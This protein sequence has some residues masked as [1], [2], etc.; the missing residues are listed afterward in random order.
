MWNGQQFTSP[1]QDLGPGSTIQQLSVLPTITNTTSNLSGNTKAVLLVTGFLNLGGSGNVSAA[2]YNGTT[3][4]PYLVASASDGAPG[5]FGRVFFKSYSMSVHNRRYMAVPFVILV[6]IASSLGVTFVLIL[7][8]LVVL[9]VKRR[10]EAKVECA[11]PW[12]YAG[13]PPL[14]PDA[15]LDMLTSGALATTGLYALSGGAGGDHDLDHSNEKGS[16]GSPLR[17][18]QIDAVQDNDDGDDD[19]STYGGAALGAGAAL[20][21][22]ATTM[23]NVTPSNG[24]PMSPPPAAYM[25]NPSSAFDGPYN[26]TSREMATVPP[27]LNTQRSSLSTNPFRVSS[28][29]IGMA[30]TDSPTSQQQQDT[31][32]SRGIVQGDVRWTDVNQDTSTLTYQNLP[33]NSQL[34]QQ[35]QQPNT[36]MMTTMTMPV[37]SLAQIERFTHDSVLWPNNDETQQRQQN[38][39]QQPGQQPVMWTHTTPERG[40][41]MVTNNNASGD[42][43]QQQPGQQ[44]GQQPVMWAHTTPERG[45]AMIANNNTSGGD[46]QQQQQLEQQPVTWTHTVPE[47][48]QALVTN[49]NMDG[50]DIQQQPPQQPAQQPV[51]WTNTVPERGQAMVTSN[52]ATDSTLFSL[53]PSHNNSYDHPTAIGVTAGFGAAV[54]AAAAMGARSS[55]LSVSTTSSSVDQQP[56]AATRAVTPSP[57]STYTSALNYQSIN[58]SHEHTASQDEG[59]SDENRIRWTHFDTENSQ[60]RLVIN[61]VSNTTPSMYSQYS[62]GD[63]LGGSPMPSTHDLGT[64]TT[65]GTTT[66]GASTASALGLSGDGLSSD[67]DIARWTT[68]PSQQQQPPSDDVAAVPP[69][70]VSMLNNSSSSHEEEDRPGSSMDRTTYTSGLRFSSVVLPDDVALP[71]KQSTSSSFDSSS[72][73]RSSTVSSLAS[74]YH[75]TINDFSH[76]QTTSNNISSQQKSTNDV[77]SEQQ[78]QPL[79]SSTTTTTNQHSTTNS[80]NT[81]QPPPLETFDTSTSEF[82]WSDI[83]ASSSPIQTTSTLPL[84]IHPQSSSSPLDISSSP[85]SAAAAA[86]AATATAATA[87]S[88]LDGRAASK[89]MIQDY[90]SSRD[91]TTN[92]ASLPDTLSAKRQKYKSDFKR[93]MQ[94]AL[95]N[96]SKGNATCSQEQPYLYVAKFDFS[97]RE[98][99]ELGFEKGDPIIVIDAEDDIWWMGYKDFKVG[100]DFDDD[101]DEPPQGVFPSNYVERATFLPY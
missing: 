61:Q 78:Q 60:D 13:K 44:S 62:L 81:A 94:A 64:T 89:K 50:S 35:Q 42:G 73:R 85:P 10:Q 59:E 92:T 77:F 5:V 3:W 20:A 52:N 57:F 12:T 23:R 41:A 17:S 24:K 16:N 46:L 74:S 4:I 19:G 9:G 68:A 95:E 99:G 87:H 48:G 25:S 47:R 22:G 54:V 98:H 86:T 65:A 1:N 30:Y 96:N 97:A 88:A 51:M 90:F 31:L 84:P 55:T 15:L 34:Q 11:Q 101:D 100:K 36:A 7:A 75:Q 43:I 38:L 80:S 32:A 49:N 76:P 27:P 83:V 18:N 39:G 91:T 33:T 8:S 40:Q 56:R 71:R 2:L 28:P 21:A 67:P 72:S 79:S 6:S 53:P 69:L 26:A 14:A 70:P 29:M 45:Q 37:M 93:A 82:R 58:D 63:Y 66:D